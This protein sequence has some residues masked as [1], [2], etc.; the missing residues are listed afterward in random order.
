MNV[1]VYG[2]AR[3]WLF[4]AMNGSGAAYRRGS[5]WR[6]WCQQGSSSRGGCGHGTWARR[7]R[8]SALVERSAQHHRKEYTA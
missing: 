4:C 8:G 5:R 6:W 3:Q 1:R 2:V 7:G